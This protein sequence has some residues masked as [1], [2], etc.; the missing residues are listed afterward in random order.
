MDVMSSVIRG[1]ENTEIEKR[2]IQKVSGWCSISDMRVRV[3]VR[4]G[5]G[6]E[7]IC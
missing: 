7:G 1:R 5:R 6:N 3:T 4:G 2:I